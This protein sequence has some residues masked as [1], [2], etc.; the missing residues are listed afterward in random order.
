MIRMTSICLDCQARKLSSLNRFN[1]KTFLEP[2]KESIT[3]LI[4]ER[5]WTLILTWYGFGLQCYFVA[6]WLKTREVTVMFRLGKTC[7]TLIWG[8]SR[9]RISLKL[10]KLTYLEHSIQTSS[11]IIPNR[12]FRNWP[13]QYHPERLI[14]ISS[15]IKLHYKS[16]KV[17]PAV[18]IRGGLLSWKSS[19]TGGPKWQ[20][21]RKHHTMKRL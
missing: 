6:W 9:R 5:K 8:G 3:P 20:M 12:T 17:S 1:I 18:K 16:K 15:P 21:L 14:N 13:N 10:L 11:K 7:T 4:S 19:P 2:G